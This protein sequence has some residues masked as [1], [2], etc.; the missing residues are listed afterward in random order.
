MLY[1]MYSEGLV[2]MIMQ[3]LHADKALDGIHL[4]IHYD[5]TEQIVSHD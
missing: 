2:V 1:D 3:D 4:Y 5:I